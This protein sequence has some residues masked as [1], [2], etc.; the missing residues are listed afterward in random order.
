MQS[1]DSAAGI[2]Q[3]ERTRR[4]SQRYVDTPEYRDIRRMITSLRPTS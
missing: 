1:A 2:G 3:C 4:L